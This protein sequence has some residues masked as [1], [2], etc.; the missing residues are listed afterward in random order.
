MQ[1]QKN[2]IVAVVT[3]GSEYLWEKG[4]AGSTIEEATTNVLR[5]MT[6]KGALSF[7][8]EIAPEVIV[9]LEELSNIP[10]EVPEH[11]GLVVFARS[12]K[13]D[14]EISGPLRFMAI[15]VGNF[16]VDHDRTETVEVTENKVGFVNTTAYNAESVYPLPKGSEEYVNGTWRPVR[17]VYY[18]C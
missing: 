13:Y 10:E 2:R 16:V 9:P 5:Q 11:C 4:Q 15:P 6:E 14:G 3:G 17:E 8:V 18:D 1:V 12:S 7:F